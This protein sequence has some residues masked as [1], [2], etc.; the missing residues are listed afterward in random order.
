[1]ISFKLSDGFLFKMLVYISVFHT[2]IRTCFVGLFAVFFWGGGFLLNSM[3]ARLNTKERLYLG[4][5]A[6]ELIFTSPGK[7]R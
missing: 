4:V 7:L 2:I 6:H 3:L 1:M 5:A